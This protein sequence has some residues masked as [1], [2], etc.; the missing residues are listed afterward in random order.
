MSNSPVAPPNLEVLFDDIAR[1][2]D[3]AP[4]L[5]ER[6][7]APEAGAAGV[8]P[9]PSTAASD[10]GSIISG[11]TSSTGTSGSNPQGGASSGAGSGT[12]IPKVQY[13]LE[14]QDRFQQYK[15]LGLPTRMVKAYCIK[16]GIKPPWSHVLK[17][18][19]CISF[20]IK[21][22]CNNRCGSN[23]DH[24]RHTKQQDDEL[25]KWCQAHYRMTDSPATELASTTA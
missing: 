12:D 21:G 23:G 6:Y 25:E 22:V 13:N 20:H 9:T 10:A 15:E 19:M 3:W 2:K 1:G 8:L 17:K 16:K 4:L 7:L 24:K 11:L 14:Y 18:P 5:P